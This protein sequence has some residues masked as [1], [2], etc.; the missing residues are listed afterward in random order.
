MAAKWDPV[1]PEFRIN[2]YPIYEVLVEEEPLHQSPYGPLVIS[3]YEDIM[4]VLRHPGASNDFRKSPQ[5]G[6]LFEEPEAPAP[7]FLFLDPPDHTRLRGLVN[8]AFT[9]KRIEQLRPRAQQIVDEILEKA[10][11][12]GGMEVV[13]EL[14]FPLPV[15]VI[16]ELLGVP[17]EDVGRFKDWSAAMAR[18]LDPGF[19]LPPGMQ[20]RFRELRKSA[21]EY[22]GELME[23]RRKSPGNDL[24]TGLIE[25]EEQGESL[26]EREVLATLNLLLIAGHET[27]VNLIANGFLAFGR[28]PEQYR[29]LREDPSL[30]R[31]AVEEVLRFDPPV[32]IMGRLPLEDIEI[33]SGT[34]PSFAD[35]VL[36]PAAANRDPR[37]FPDAGVFDI[38]RSDNRH[39]GF[40]FGIH[41]CVG[42]PLARMEAQVVFSSLAKGFEKIEAERDPPEYKDNITL[43]GIASLPVSLST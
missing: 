16:C 34:V 28:Q 38:G 31:S 8:R 10:A 33:P 6:P 17:A 13:S 35:V 37:Q 39:L 41:H 9:P 4:A 3:R 12:A 26:S 2:P 1:S 23:R 24:L 19:T 40:G 27:T 18:G 25:A 20:Q 30:V 29:R 32:H 14:A 42:A 15:L 11:A 5:W 43:R 36:L 22:F 7:S 21:L